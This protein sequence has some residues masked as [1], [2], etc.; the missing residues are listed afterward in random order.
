M[1]V[2]EN[3]NANWITAFSF[4]FEI[5]PTYSSIV[6]VNNFLC[7][8]WKK[9][10]NTYRQPLA[11][12]VVWEYREIS[13]FSHASV[14]RIGK[15]PIAPVLSAQSVMLSVLS[16]LIGQ[17]TLRFLATDDIGTSWLAVRPY[18]LTCLC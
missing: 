15:N 10:Y 9:S 2:F 12:D 17:T 13:V 7:S 16:V 6:N 4:S 3:E 8:I 18:A 14:L 1:Q 5:S 11:S